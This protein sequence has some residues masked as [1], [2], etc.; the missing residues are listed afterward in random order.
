MGQ[1]TR[2]K[3]PGETETGAHTPTDRLRREKSER[4]GG[5]KSQENKLR[6]AAVDNRK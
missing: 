5:G 2:E 1:R 4:R 6:G 3:V